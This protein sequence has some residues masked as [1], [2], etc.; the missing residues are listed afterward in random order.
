MQNPPKVSTLGPPL[1]SYTWAIT[2]AP[3]EGPRRP[4]RGPRGPQGAPRAPW[5]PP[6]A[7]PG[8]RGSPGSTF[9]HLIALGPL[10]PRD[11]S[12]SA[13]WQA[14]LDNFLCFVCIWWRSP[15]GS[16][17]AFVAAEKHQKSNFE[18]DADRVI[19]SRGVRIRPPSCPRR[20]K[21]DQKGEQPDLP[22]PKPSLMFPLHM[23][24][25]SPELYTK[26]R[27]GLPPPGPRWGPRGL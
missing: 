17:A 15:W 20:P 11:K 26:H 5:G 12:L 10:W 1:V 3:G 19:F 7:P 13:S 6:G 16:P 9:C 2:W 25:R 8:G 21:K 22:R 4:P 14:R 23:V 18:I 27:R 24:W